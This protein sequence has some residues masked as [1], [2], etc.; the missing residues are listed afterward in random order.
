MIYMR[1]EEKREHDTDE[2][3]S[4]SKAE[5]INDYR[6]GISKLSF[7]MNVRDLLIASD[8]FMIEAFEV[9]SSHF[10]GIRLKYWCS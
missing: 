10:G 4:R 6:I 7:E 2:N 8:L 1:Y 3:E 5:S 9:K